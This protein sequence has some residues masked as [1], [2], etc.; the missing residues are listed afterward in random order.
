M[1]SPYRVEKLWISIILVTGFLGGCYK[2]V[3][4]MPGG[5][6]TSETA[7]ITISPLT[8]ATKTTHGYFPYAE[9][10]VDYQKS[11]ADYRVSRWK[12]LLQSGDQKALD[13]FLTMH[14]TEIDW[15]QVEYWINREDQ[16]SLKKAKAKYA[17]FLR[18]T[19]QSADASKRY[20]LQV[21][22]RPE[23]SAIRLADPDLAY[24]SGWL[25]PPGEYRIKVRKDGYLTEERSIKIEDHPVTITIELKP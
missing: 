19:N 18:R 16:E 21:N 8:T 7:M 9:T 14:A 23:D 2:N 10:Y 5:I 3:L 11:V 15:V 17:L 13:E 4:Y 12:A 20:P 1:G 25:L 6:S 22:V 24:E